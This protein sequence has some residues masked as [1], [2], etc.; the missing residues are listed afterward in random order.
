MDDKIYTITLEDGTQLKN[1]RLNGNNF[2]SDKEIVPSVFN[3]RLG[4]VIISDGENEEVHKNMALVQVTKMGNEYLFILRD[5]SP[6][7][8]E[9]AKLRADLDYL[10]MMTN[11]EI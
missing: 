8:I 5:V 7:E 1:L 9:K 11:V 10:A 4:R 6:E 2:V 3:G